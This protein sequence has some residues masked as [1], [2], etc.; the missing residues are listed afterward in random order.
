MKISF[1]N[2]IY[3]VALI[4]LFS[5]LTLCWFLFLEFSNKGKILWLEGDRQ[6]W[7]RRIKDHK[8]WKLDEEI[9]NWIYDK[10]T[11]PFILAEH[12]NPDLNVK[13]LLDELYTMGFIKGVN[14]N[15]GRHLTEAAYENRAHEITKLLTR[16]QNIAE[17]EIDPNF[18]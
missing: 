2:Q 9:W 4:P 1:E 17:P 5:I 6:W 18:L 7:G 16:N 15:N 13:K 8:V 11:E 12:E 3:L 14:L 10:Y